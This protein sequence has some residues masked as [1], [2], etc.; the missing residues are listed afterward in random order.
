MKNMNGEVLSKLSMLEEI[1]ENSSY[2]MFSANKITVNKDE[3]LQLIKDIRL[4]LPNDVKQANWV[5][6]E[7]SKILEQARQIADEKVKE[8]EEFCRKSASEHEITK[9]AEKNANEIMDNA[10]MHADAVIEGA[11]GYAIDMLK[12]L[13]DNIEKIQKRLENNKKEL[14]NFEFN[15]KSN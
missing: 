10:E 15:K 3:I 1:I 2:A 11:R 7:K 8:T 6:K 12:E 4:S 14:E 9:L 5:Q 13:D